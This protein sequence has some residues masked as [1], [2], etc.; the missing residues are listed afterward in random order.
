MELRFNGLELGVGLRVRVS[1]LY[2]LNLPKVTGR[3]SAD[4]ADVVSST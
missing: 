1:I 4:G 3:T 2:A